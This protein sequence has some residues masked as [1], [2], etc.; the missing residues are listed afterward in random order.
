MDR[1]TQWQL[2][3]MDIGATESD[4]RAMI[5][6]L[7]TDLSDANRLAGAFVIELFQTI[8]ADNMTSV[9]KLNATPAYAGSI[10]AS[11]DFCDANMAM[12]QA[13]QELLNREPDMQS[14][15][16][17]A[18]WNEAWQIAKTEYL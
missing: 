12:D 7:D 18:L 5:A 9:R 4:A 16:D 13:F 11:H 2:D 10:C 8:G 1:T 14:D 15:A 3:R 6:F 17:C